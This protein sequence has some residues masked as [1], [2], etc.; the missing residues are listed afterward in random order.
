[1]QQDEP[2]GK[3][4]SQGGRPVCFASH[5]RWE[6]GSVAVLPH[7]RITRSQLR[8]EDGRPPVL[9]VVINHGHNAEALGLKARLG[10]RTL[11]IDSGSALSDAERAGF[12]LALPNVY[13]SGLM[14]EI[15]ALLEGRPGEDSALVWSSDVRHPDPA[16][17]AERCREVMSDPNVGLYAPSA[18]PSS[19]IQMRACGRAGTRRVT[20]V[21]G[22]CFAAR[23]ELFQGLCPIDTTV[24]AM[25]WGLDVHLG[26]LARRLGYAAL[27]DHDVVVET[28]RGSGY[29]R[30]RARDERDA[31]YRTLP[32]SAR[33]FRRLSCSAPLQMRLGMPLV[34][35]LPW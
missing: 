7:G 14:N 16:W 20:F 5:G 19:H 2:A 28:D 33:L 9:V 17:A 18:R 35:A 13:Y 34:L 27:V 4:N 25:G 22:F 31:W 30:L 11:A 8:R 29:D 26:Y 10:P 21:E 15:A 12:D 6:G 24:N 1:M 23:R 3:G 32:A